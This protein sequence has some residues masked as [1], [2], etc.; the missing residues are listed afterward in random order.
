MGRAIG[1]DSLSKQYRLGES[2]HGAMLRPAFAACAPAWD[3]E[4]LVRPA[5]RTWAAASMAGA[6]DI[7]AAAAPMPAN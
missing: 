6:S 4:T 3:R 7:R 1:V 2:R 5:P